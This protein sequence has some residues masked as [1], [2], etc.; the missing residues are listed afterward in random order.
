MKYSAIVLAAGSGS[1]TGLNYN[2]VLHVYDGNTIIERSLSLFMDDMDCEQIILV[3]NPNEREEFIHFRFPSKIE[4][5]YGG[6]ERSDSVIEGLNKV[7]SE[8]VLIH[9]GARPFLKVEDLNVLKQN[10]EKHD[11]AILMVKSID[12]SKIVKDGVIVESLNR[13][14]VYNAQTPQGFKTDLIKSCYEKLKQTKISV[15]DD[16]QVV[17]L[18]S[19]VNI[20]CVEGSYSNTKITTIE[21][22]L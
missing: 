7:R 2:K 14:L 4:I 10:L 18:F 21:D 13:E 3:I 9:D 19:K 16:A 22:L 11:A 8:Y 17:E 15:T 6:K 12:T 20:K 5:A 1:R